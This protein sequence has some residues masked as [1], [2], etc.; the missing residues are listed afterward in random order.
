MGEKLPLEFKRAVQTEITQQAP[1]NEKINVHGEM[2][3]VLSMV[4]PC[5][6]K[7]AQEKDVDIRKM[8]CYVK[9]GK[10]K[11]NACLDKEN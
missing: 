11:N 5:M 3:D 6:I 9:C 8:M 7:E 10:K 1:D 4:I 2:L